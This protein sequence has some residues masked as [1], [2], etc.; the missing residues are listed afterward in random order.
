MYTFVSSA[1]EATV[2]VT[3]AI[4]IECHVPPSVLVP[5]IWKNKYCAEFAAFVILKVALM[6]DVESSIVAIN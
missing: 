6:F 4:G 1:N 2:P 5:T 3:Y